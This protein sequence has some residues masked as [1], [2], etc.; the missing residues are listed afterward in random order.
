MTRRSLE[1]KINDIRQTYIRIIYSNSF[2]KHITQKSNT[3]IQNSLSSDKFL[4]NINRSYSHLSKLDQMIIN[5]EFFY[6][7]YPGWWKSYFSSPLFLKLKTEAMK[8]FWEGL[9]Y[10]EN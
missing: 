10:A 2:N 8:R 5:N 7:D 6:G 3:L 4:D 1:Q 9:S